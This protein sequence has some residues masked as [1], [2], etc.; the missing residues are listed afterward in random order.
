MNDNTLIL[1]EAK[2]QAEE[3]VKK[4]RSEIMRYTLL[5]TGFGIVVGITLFCVLFLDFGGFP[6]RITAFSASLAVPFVIHIVLRSLYAAKVLDIF[7]GIIESLE[8][9]PQTASGYAARAE[10]LYA[11][12]FYKPSVEDLNQAIDLDPSTVE[13]YRLRSDI[14]E[15]LGNLDQAGT[16]RRK[17]QELA[18][19][20]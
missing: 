11:Y 7:R 15:K 8:K 3:D 12:K 5:V 19:K 4:L 13:Y 9:E 2:R 20:S 14:Y 6:F 18:D 16:D 17:A 10:A 1:E